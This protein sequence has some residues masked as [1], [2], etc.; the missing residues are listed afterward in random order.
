MKPITS[1]GP[2]RVEKSP[3]PL[4]PS[5]RAN[6]EESE[7]LATLSD[8]VAGKGEFRLKDT[9]EYMEGIAPG[10]DPR[11]AQR[12]HGGDYSVQRHL[13][14]HGLTVEEAHKAVLTL[15]DE[16]VRCGDRCLL[17]VHGRGLNS[18]DGR[19]VL[20]EQVKLW[21][22]RGRLA[23][24]VLAFATARPCDG[25]SGAVYVLLRKSRFHHFKPR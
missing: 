16:A 13:D 1:R 4:L 8:L 5:P 18:P 25:G 14:L 6:S 17:L 19:P 7:V 20:K 11:L 21:L 3:P 9:P 23:R 12:L 24:H 22:S 2:E 10:V 15:F